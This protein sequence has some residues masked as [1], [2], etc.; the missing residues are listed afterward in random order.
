MKDHWHYADGFS[1]TLINSRKF[2]ILLR[3][4]KVSRKGLTVRLAQFHGEC[5]MTK[6]QWT[7]PEIAEKYGIS[8]YLLQRYT[9]QELIRES[10][11]NRYGHLY[12]D[13]DMLKRILWIR[14]YQKAGFTLPEIASFIDADDEKIAL[15]LSNK[16]NELLRQ[17]DSIQKILNILQ[18]L[19]SGNIPDDEL[20]L[21]NEIREVIK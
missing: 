21:E 7:V 17:R 6:I 20:D 14:L 3:K 2:Q 15:V 19:I 5:R 8:R 18:K 4:Q 16:K 10:G 9:R 11:R 12:Y 13:E 1:F